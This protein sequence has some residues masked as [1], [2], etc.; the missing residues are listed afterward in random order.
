MGKIHHAGDIELTDDYRFTRKSWIAERAGWGLLMSILAAAL[1]GGLAPGLFSECTARSGALS[2]DYDRVGHLKT[3]ETILVRL[4]P[5]TD[6]S[7]RIAFWIDQ[8]FLD[9]ISI[10]EIRPMPLEV[11]PEEDRTT[12]VFA[13]PPPHSTI[14][15]RLAIAPDKPG[16]LSGRFG[17]AKDP[18]VDVRQFIY[19]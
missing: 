13:A 1:L 16:R 17:Q 5:R 9:D 19:P 11:R 10:Q 6:D 14:A 2:V 4:T 12:F 18:G 15:V 8:K 7:G 3:D